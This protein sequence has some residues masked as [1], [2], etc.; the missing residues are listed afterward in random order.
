MIHWQSFVVTTNL[1]HY[2]CNNSCIDIKW[3]H[4]GLNKT[5]WRAMYVIDSYYYDVTIIRVLSYNTIHIII[6]F[7]SRLNRNDL[8]LIFSRDVHRKSNSKDNWKWSK[9]ILINSINI[10]NNIPLTWNGIHR[11]WWLSK[12]IYW[13]F[14]YWNRNW[15]NSILHKLVWNDDY[16]QIKIDWTSWIGIVG[17][18]EILN[19]LNLNM[20]NYTWFGFSNDDREYIAKILG[21]ILGW[22]WI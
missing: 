1:F 12:L 21:L 22:R 9:I 4:F 2:I 13:L 17:N 15:W 10:H 6:T 14:F 11:W 18:K 16:V 8:N 5:F 19:F 3:C 7:L 20:M